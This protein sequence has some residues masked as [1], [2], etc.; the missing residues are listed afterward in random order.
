MSGSF[1]RSSI[2]PH[3]RTVFNAMDGE[4][5]NRTIGL[6]LTES[7]QIAIH[8]LKAGYPC[9]PDPPCCVA[10]ATAPPPAP[11]SPCFSHTGSS[12]PQDP[13]TYCELSLACC[14]SGCPEPT[15]PPHLPTRF[16]TDCSQYCA[17]VT[18]NFIG[19]MSS[20]PLIGFP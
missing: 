6:Q 3:S 19:M 11:P 8:Q 15:L 18:M 10:P 20:G 2:H 9:S 14:S 13:R 7:K 12:L 16:L 17:E 4:V 5:T 1:R